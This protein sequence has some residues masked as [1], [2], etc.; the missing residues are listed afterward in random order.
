VVGGGALGAGLRSLGTTAGRAAAQL[1]VVLAVLIGLEAGNRF[2]DGGRAVAAA[3]VGGGRRNLV[4]YRVLR[5]LVALV[6]RGQQ[7]L[8][9]GT[10]R[11]DL[12]ACLRQQR[13]WALLC[14]QL[15]QK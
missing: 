15:Q 9:V 7:W 10:V 2:G 11:A 13:Q 12:T 6:Q 4:S 3:V 14:V 8:R 5:L 1:L